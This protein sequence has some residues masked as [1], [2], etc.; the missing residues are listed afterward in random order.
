MNYSKK[1]SFQMSRQVE[2]E[3]K[4]GELP[5]LVLSP[6]LI[7]DPMSSPAFATSS[8]SSPEF[9]KDG[10]ISGLSI[11]DMNVEGKIQNTK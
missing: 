1:D 11:L 10:V 3:V 6:I 9:Q 8:A 4:S 7:Y 5:Q 2:K